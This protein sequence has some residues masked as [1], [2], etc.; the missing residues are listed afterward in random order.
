[1]ASQYHISSLVVQVHPSGQ[2]LAR[3]GISAI[4]GAEI[5][6]H[7]AEHKLVVTLES[8]DSRTAEDK[9]AAIGA[10]DGVLSTVLVY[11]QVAHLSEDL[12]S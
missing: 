11:Q 12:L 4:E 5:H 9:V 10:L 8:A 7:T 6:A 1:M 2:A 3:A